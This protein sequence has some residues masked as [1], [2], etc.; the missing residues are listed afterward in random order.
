MLGTIAAV[1]VQKVKS[2]STAGYPYVRL[3]G[4]AAGAEGQDRVDSQD[5]KG[6]LRAE[7]LRVRRGLPQDERS[8][9]A[10]AL[11]RHALDLPVLASADTVAAYVSVGAEPGTRDLLDVLRGQGTRVLLPVLLPDNDLDWAVYEGAG[12]LAPAGRGLLEPDGA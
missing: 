11:A 12:S 7:L 2:S 6:T 1:H 4:T 5:T 3:P 9:A 10:R 8:A